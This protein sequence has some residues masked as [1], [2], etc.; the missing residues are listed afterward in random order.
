MLQPATNCC[1]GLSNGDGSISSA[2]PIIF[3]R[4]IE[5]AMMDHRSHPHGPRTNASM[6][7]SA[8]SDPLPPLEIIALR[9][10]SFDRLEAQL[11]SAGPPL[12]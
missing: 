6:N 10:R 1:C 12:I 8:I 4:D 9:Q 11:L 7:A 5:I 2:Q 3:S